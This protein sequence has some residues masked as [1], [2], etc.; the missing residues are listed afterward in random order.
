M[1]TGNLTFPSLF[2]KESANVSY[3]VSQ[4]KWHEVI[5]VLV[6]R[7][8]SSFSVSLLPMVS[9]RRDPRLSQAGT[10][11]SYTHSVSKG[12]LLMW[13]EMPTGIPGTRVAPDRLAG[14]LLSFSPDLCQPLKL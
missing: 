14:L 5:S 12:G 10:H 13:P 4:A 6:R 8:S 1:K 11:L 2:P 3:W 9:T 7:A